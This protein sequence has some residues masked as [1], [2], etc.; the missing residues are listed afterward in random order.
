VP[1]FFKFD[2]TV[3]YDRPTFRIGLK[4][5]NLTDKEYWMSD[6]DAE[7]QSPRT[8]IANFTMRF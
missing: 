3:F 5:N 1:G 4:I 6:Y 7:P 2:G 8:F